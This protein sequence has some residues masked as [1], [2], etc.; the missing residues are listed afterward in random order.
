[1]P[2]VSNYILGFWLFFTVLRENLYTQ[3]GLFFGCL[4]NSCIY[5]LF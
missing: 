3:L 2:A 1:M 5:F 4:S